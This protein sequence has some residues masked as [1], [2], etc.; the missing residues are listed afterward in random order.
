MRNQEQRTRW[1]WGGREG[2]PTPAFTLIELLVVIS[3]IALLVG[4]LIPAISKAKEAGR[5]TRCLVNLRSLGTALQ[6]YMQQESKDL[7]PKVRP[8]NNGSTP[9]DPSILDVLEKYL[10]A[11]KPVSK[12]AE[13]WVVS[14]PWRC[15][16]D[17]GGTDEASGFRPTW[18]RAGS[19]YLFTPGE[20]YTAGE[21]LL[22]PNLAQAV[23]RTCQDFKPTIPMFIDADDWHHPRFG[24]GG[25]GEPE[26]D[27]KEWHWRQGT[28]LV[29]AHAE[30]SAWVSPAERQRFIQELLR[31]G[32]R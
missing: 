6:M 4:I 15:P 20:V 32:G 8:D 12:G 31:A 30:R 11:P 28:Y 10:D 23:T 29:D 25:F 24:S 2:S 17:R 7:L 18:R 14:E 5:R 9:S 16:S 22:L 27:A 19:S 13:D 1:A 26:R 3:I 21:L